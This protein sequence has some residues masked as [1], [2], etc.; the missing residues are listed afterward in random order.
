MRL[1]VGCGFH[2]LEGFVNIDNLSDYQNNLQYFK[3]G[4][5][6]EFKN[7]TLDKYIENGTFIVK[8]AT[9]LDYPKNSI[10]EIRS[11]RFIGRYDV[12]IENYYDMLKDR[13]KLK[14]YCSKW[15]DI[16]IKKLINT[17][18]YIKIRQGEIYEHNK[19]EQDVHII[20][21]KDSWLEINKISDFADVLK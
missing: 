1:N 4:Y 2:I 6:N 20:C 16:F 7:G 12:D 14:I 19:D 9:I 17:F 5:E 15:N 11:Y 8:D 21:F 18:D 13:G 3:D 10:D